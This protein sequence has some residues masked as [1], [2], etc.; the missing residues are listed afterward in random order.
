MHE[1]KN[2]NRDEGLQPDFVKLRKFVVN[3]GNAYVRL[4]AKD[5]RKVMRLLEKLA[6]GKASSVSYWDR[7]SKDDMKSCCLQIQPISQKMANDLRR[8]ASELLETER[9]KKL[10]LKCLMDELIIRTWIEEP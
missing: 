9:N 4:A 5:R 6:F 10:D 8:W 2:S 7:W 1:P 3:L